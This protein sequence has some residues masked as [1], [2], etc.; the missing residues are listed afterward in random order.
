MEEDQEGDY[1]EICGHPLICFRCLLMKQDHLR[2][3]H[4]G[5]FYCEQDHEG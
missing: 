4:P 5:S 1:C 3:D 2:E